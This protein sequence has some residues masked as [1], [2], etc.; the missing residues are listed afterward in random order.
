LF[1]IGKIVSSVS[2][3]GYRELRILFPTGGYDKRDARFRG[4]IR[5]NTRLGRVK[6]S[7]ICPVFQARQS[8]D[9]A[10]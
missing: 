2:F 3:Q 9:C 8:G 4:E 10:S 7:P 5:W 6:A 1:G